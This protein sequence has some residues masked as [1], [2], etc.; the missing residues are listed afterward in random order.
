MGYVFTALQNEVP[1]L[2]L[3]WQP[4]LAPPITLEQQKEAMRALSTALGLPASEQ[5]TKVMHEAFWK[6]VEAQGRAWAASPQGARLSAGKT[7][8]QVIAEARV[9]F[10]TE[11][12]HYGFFEGTTAKF[13]SINSRA[14]QAAFS[15]W[16]SS[17]PPPPAN[18]FVP[19]LPPPPSGCPPDS[20][21][22]SDS[23]I[24]PDGRSIRIQTSPVCIKF[25]S[26]G[27]PASVSAK[28]PPGPCS[29]EI[30][31]REGI[32]TT[33]EQPPV[34]K[35]EWLKENWKWLVALAVVGAGAVVLVRQTKSKR[36]I[37]ELGGVRL[38]YYMFPTSGVSYGPIE[39]QN[40]RHAR[41]RLAEI[42]GKLPRRTQVWETTRKD[43]EALDAERRRDPLLYR[44]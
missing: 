21:D 10:D 39:A 26:A 17:P 6:L 23:C 33:T 15:V 3:G 22:N 32:K 7:V 29:A 34:A 13:P 43:M 30:L 12:P 18:G 9:R 38:F 44:D 31:S 36:T 4:R 11:G 8:T 16:R 24:A 37:G 14:V 2:G 5:Y 28:R 42:W 19:P 1:L 40:L 20:F 27:G 25:P 41:K 35:Q